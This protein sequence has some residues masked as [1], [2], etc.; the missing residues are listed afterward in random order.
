[1]TVKP[2]IPKDN[3]ELPD[4]Y[5]IKVCYATG[6]TEELELASHNFN[7]ETGIFECWTK[8]DHCN[9]LIMENIVRIEF[10]KRFSK[11]IAIKVKNDNIKSAG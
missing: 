5:G 8:E 2:F 3:H 9:W 6:K 11:M 10:D 4:H 7:K 1:M